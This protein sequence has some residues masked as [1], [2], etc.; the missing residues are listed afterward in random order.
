MVA[1]HQHISHQPVAIA[2]DGAAQRLKV[3]IRGFFSCG[4]ITVPGEPGDLGSRISNC[5]GGGV[6]GTKQRLLAGIEHGIAGK[7]V[8]ARELRQRRADRGG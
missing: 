7:V 8:D 5:G 6:G 4:E 1:R 2:L 3:G